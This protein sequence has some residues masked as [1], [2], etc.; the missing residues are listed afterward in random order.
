ML[1]S[2]APKYY[3]LGAILSAVGALVLA[4]RG[5]RAAKSVPL[6]WAPIAVGATIV[7]LGVAAIATGISADLEYNARLNTTVMEYDVS[8]GM[9]GSWLVRILLPAPRDP[10]FFD[11]LN[12]S[13]GTASLRLNRTATDTNV[14]VTTQGNV[15]FRIRAEI[16]TADVDPGFTRMSSP[17]QNVC[18]S[19]CNATVELGG[20]P[21][22]AKV[23]LNL[24]A[25]IGV[26]CESHLLGLEAWISE[27]VA[28]YPAWMPMMVC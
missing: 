14:V 6:P 3:F 18:Y 8:I 27:G 25:S 19:G 15:T 17:D 2:P 9:N 5:R 13:N 24:Q 11:S 4:L 26:A 7:A 1:P 23:F 12:A 16:P 22:G 10:R 28:R 20:V 21:A